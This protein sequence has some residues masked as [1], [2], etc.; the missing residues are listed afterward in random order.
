M[1]T[2][3]LYHR[4]LREIGKLRTLY[5]DKIGAYRWGLLNSNISLEL[6]IPSDHEAVIA[7]LKNPCKVEI[8]GIIFHLEEKDVVYAG[9]GHTVTIEGL[10]E[11]ESLI[12]IG[13]GASNRDIDP[14]IKRFR[15]VEGFT[16]GYQG[17]RRDIYVLIGEEDP[18]ERLLA[19]YTEG[20]PGEWTSYPPHKHDDKTEVY[21]YYGL[22]RGFG[23]QMVEDETGYEVYKVRDWDAMVFKRG[24]HPNVPSPNSRICYLWILCQVVGERSLKVEVHPDFRDVPMGKSHLRR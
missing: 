1:S 5:E 11:G 16:S 14:Y 3:G 10:D 13:E 9:R 8:D 2:R 6:K 4:A 18:A 23:L 12:V 19:G 20:W 17:Y 24:Y 22:E 7:C 15:E 21:V